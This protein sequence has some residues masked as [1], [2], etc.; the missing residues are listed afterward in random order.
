MEMDPESFEKLTNAAQT[1]E[2]A[3]AA[4]AKEIE[5]KW[6]RLEARVNNK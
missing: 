2:R 1:E 4:K 5:L 6:A 3:K